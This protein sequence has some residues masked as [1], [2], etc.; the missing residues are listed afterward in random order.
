MATLLPLDIFLDELTKG[1]I[2]IHVNFY[3]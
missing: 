3:H 1:L 2:G